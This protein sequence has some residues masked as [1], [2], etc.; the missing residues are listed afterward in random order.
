[1]RTRLGNGIGVLG[2]TGAGMLLFLA[3]FAW[4]RSPLRPAA[5]AVREL[6]QEEA[7]PEERF[8]LV[9]GPAGVRGDWRDEAGQTGSL[10]V[11]VGDS[12]LKIHA[13]G[14]GFGRT[15]RSCRD[16]DDGACPCACC[17]R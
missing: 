7:R 13:R 8:S 14:T 3:G 9:I 16:H 2:V 11:D 12:R 10:R 1:M 4:G 17:A 5:A 15:P 6:P